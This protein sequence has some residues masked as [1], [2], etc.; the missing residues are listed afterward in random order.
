MQTVSIGMIPVFITDITDL[1]WGIKPISSVPLFSLFFFSE[2]Q[3]NLCS[4]MTLFIIV[5]FLDPPVDISFNTK[6]CVTN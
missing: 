1:G 3:K 4:S 2:L 5:F 6:L